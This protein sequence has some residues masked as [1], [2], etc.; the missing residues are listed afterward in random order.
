MTAFGSGTRR[1][2]SSPR[3]TTATRIVTLA[4]QPSVTSRAARTGTYSSERAGWQAAST[5]AASTACSA[6]EVL[7]L[8]TLGYH[9]DGIVSGAAVFHIGWVGAA[10][11]GLAELPMLSKAMSSAREHATDRMR[12]HA[13]RLGATGVVGVKLSIEA[14]A[15]RRH[16]A[17]V[18]AVGTAVSG[19]RPAELAGATVPPPFLAAMSA[20][21]L[22][23]LA[24][25]GYTAVDLAMGVCVFHIPRQ[26]F[27]ALA[28]LRKSKELARYTS[29]LYAA[30]EIAMRRVQDDALRAEAGGVVGVSV[31]Q[32]SHVWGS[33][34]IEFFAM[35][36]AVRTLGRGRRPQADPTPPRA[37]EPRTK[38][39]LDMRD[40]QTVTDPAALQGRRTL[41]VR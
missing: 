41:S 29:A 13:S 3:A 16:L 27:K 7:V 32:S 1:S 26:P 24:R 17:R 39:A 22:A 6:D 33:R 11:S 31:K 18:I 14:F 28:N 21:E 40:D 20:Q 4:N 19:R 38:L 30:R 23:M 8:E 34:T 35:G 15:E 12:D 9:V 37:Q 2:G 10:T 5:R 25:V 36:T